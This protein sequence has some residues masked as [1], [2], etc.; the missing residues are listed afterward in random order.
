MIIRRCAY[1]LTVVAAAVLLLWGC[2]DGGS[3]SGLIEN[4]RAKKQKTQQKYEGL[5]RDISRM[6][7]EANIVRVADESDYNALVGAII[8][9]LSSCKSRDDVRRVVHG[10]FVQRFTA[11]VAGPESRYDGVAGRIWSRMNKA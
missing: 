6:L 11:R 4:L 1:P 2:S 5:S 8:P 7:Q 9:R 3:G 10:A